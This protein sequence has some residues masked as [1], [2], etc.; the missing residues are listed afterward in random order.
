LLASLDDPD[1]ETRCEQAAPT[2]ANR[3]NLRPHSVGTDYA[4]WPSL[5]ELAE[6]EPFSSLSEKRKGALID[7]DREAL[8]G[9]APLP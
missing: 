8:E 5:P 6:V 7:I 4:A 1:L 9:R 3:F 2:P